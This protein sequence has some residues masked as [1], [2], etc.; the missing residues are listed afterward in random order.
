MT[1][2]CFNASLA[3]QIYPLFTNAWDQ[4]KLRKGPFNEFR[5]K[6]ACLAKL[7][8]CSNKIVDIYQRSLPKVIC[9]GIQTESVI[10]IEEAAASLL[11]A[12]CVA[13]HI[14]HHRATAS[15]IMNLNVD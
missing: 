2:K 14:E 3:E 6:I 13:E 12:G 5:G 10:C 8:A 7:S 11:K 15:R 9:H 1:G 4:Q